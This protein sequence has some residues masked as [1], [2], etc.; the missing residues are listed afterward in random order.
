MRGIAQ[1][2]L[3][4][5]GGP[6]STAFPEPRGSSHLG[7]AQD[8]G[9]VPHFPRPLRHLSKYLHVPV[10]PSLVLSPSLLFLDA[11]RPPILQPP[12]S[13]PQP[14]PLCLAPVMRT[15]SALA[16]APPNLGHS[17][18]TYLPRPL[19]VAHAW[20][21]FPRTPKKVWA[22]LSHSHTLCSSHPHHAWDRLGF[23]LSPQQR[24]GQAF[25]P[26]SLVS[27]FHVPSSLL[28][29][30]SLLSSLS[31]FF[32]SFSPPCCLHIL[33]IPYMFVEGGGICLAFCSRRPPR[34][35]TGGTHS[36]RGATGLQG[37]TLGSASPGS[38]FHSTPR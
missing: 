31:P 5:S 17:A 6:Q 19:G 13:A 15:S 12:S 26:P 2:L 30:S 9:P 21:A 34:G 37:A 23:P 29:L 8:S 14:P 38:P 11:M 7:V 4:G 33:G 18:W 20:A 16:C 36:A 35:L 1:G 10:T 25:L 27:S 24:A 3:G 32:P 28:P 22:P